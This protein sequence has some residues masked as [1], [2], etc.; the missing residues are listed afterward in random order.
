CSSGLTASGSQNRL[1][2]RPD[3]CGSL[4]RQLYRGKSFLA[5]GLLL[6]SRTGS[7]IPFWGKNEEGHGWFVGVLHQQIVNC[8]VNLILWNLTIQRFCL[9]NKH[10]LLVMSLLF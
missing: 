9:S 4:L 2:H 6:C 7:K 5:H 10:N 8:S 1:S 3:R